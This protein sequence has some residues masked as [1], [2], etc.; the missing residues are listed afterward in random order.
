MHRPRRNIPFLEILMRRRFAGIRRGFTLLELIVAISVV[1]MLTA[2]LLPAV[3]QAREAARL[4]QC[5]NNLRQMGIA[6]TA[7]H[8]SHRCFP[9][10]ALDGWSWIAEIL[11]EVDQANLQSNLNLRLELG[12]AMQTGQN[13]G[14]TDAVLPALLCPSDPNGSSIFV[15]TEFGGRRFAHTNYL[16]TESSG[17]A[18]ENGMFDLQNCL[19]LRDVVDGTS[20]TLFVGERGI[21]RVNNKIGQ[22][23]WWTFGASYETVMSVAGGMES[24]PTTGVQSIQTWWGYHPGGVP[25]SF[26]DGSVHFMNNSMDPTVFLAL[27]TRAGGEMAHVN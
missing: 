14:I 5:K 2:I 6:L 11:P 22:F 10:G 25:F 17:P 24:G 18:K 20:Q 15:A 16:G 26:V 7:Y 9:G 3:Q 19:R 4:V 23:G 1:A 13:V 27:G 12:Q 21:D 8:D